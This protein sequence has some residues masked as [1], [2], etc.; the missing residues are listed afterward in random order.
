MRIV[1]A[2]RP[3]PPIPDDVPADHPL[4]DPIIDHWLESS[5]FA[6][7]VKM[8]A[9]R[10][11]LRLLGSDGLGRHLV[12]FLVAAG[13]GLS[14]DDLAVLTQTRAR[15]VERELSA[16]SGR[17]FQLRSAHWAT[18]GPHLY[19]LAHE[20]IQQS[21]LQ[22]IN[23]NELSVYRALLHQWADSYQQ[24]GWPE[25]TPEY[26]LR[27]Y[28]QLLRE[29][30]DLSQLVA[31][32]C[33]DARQERLWQV[34]GAD[35]EA[36][37]EIS[38]CF[39]HLLTEE[40]EISEQDTVTAL[41]LAISRDKL[42]D[43]MGHLPSSLVGIWAKL[44][45]VDRAINLARSQ[46]QSY[47]GERS[48]IA[49]AEALAASHGS[50][51]ALALAN[52]INDS[53]RRDTCLKEIAGALAR[54]GDTEALDVACGILDPGKRAGAYTA[55]AYELAQAR[56]RQQA[57]DTADQ[58][59]SII[60]EVGDAFHRA[61]LLATV[62]RVFSS[63]DN[64]GRAREIVDQAVSA[65]E[66]IIPVYRRAQA[67][68][69]VAQKI[70]TPDLAVVAADTSLK[71][72]NLVLTLDVDEEALWALRIVAA[73]LAATGLHEQAIELCH[74]VTDDEFDRNETLSEI[75]I[76][77]AKAGDP[78]H[79][80]ELS[81]TLPFAIHEAQVLIAAAEA[82][83]KAGQESRAVDI[84]HR[85]SEVAVRTS[86]SWQTEIMASAAEVLKMAG[87]D[88]QAT[89]V[90]SEA[91]ELARNQRN[92]RDLV[93]R[94]AELAMALSQ[95]SMRGQSL[96]LVRRARVIA[97]T[98][99]HLYGRIIGLA[100]VAKTFVGVGLDE[101]ARALFAHLVEIARSEIL[102]FERAES[103]SNIAICLAEAG[104][105][106]EAS[107]LATEILERSRSAPSPYREEWEKNAAARA[108]IAAEA[109][110]KAGALLHELPESMVSE[111][112]SSTVRGLV[113]AGQLDRA[114][115]I[116]EDIEDRRER[117]RALGYLAG[118][119]AASGDIPE[120][121]HLL[122]DISQQV[123]KDRAIPKIV[124]AA[125]KSG[126]GTAALRLIEEI[127]S[128]QYQ[129][130]AF[131]A[132]AA[133]LGPTSQGRLFLVRALSLGHWSSLIGDTG[134]VAPE[135]LSVVAD[136]L[137]ED[138]SRESLF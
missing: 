55:I 126:N 51:Q 15:L 34:T 54:T 48:L 33:D 69:R 100:T 116:M 16:V 94:L 110:D 89:S 105:L 64:S 90:A 28:A 114:F 56:K 12:G 14:A 44:G 65:A 112:L 35:L 27:G 128:E 11:L 75:G 24:R 87:L 103:L 134:Y 68:G 6:Q 26:L 76:A 120:A 79:A 123:M 95:V 20:E 32:A 97:E 93:R 78:E 73:A 138:S 118:A 37:T 52:S 40:T 9:E 31:L 127:D 98:E 50:R 109:Y 115:E 121:I 72:A 66:T 63:I 36:L 131:G 45:N 53:T 84:V 80:L 7:A 39:D 137:L 106:R 130:S 101:E 77:L 57:E 111:L 62:A 46:E 13:G 85:V 21:A 43:R 71:A 17:S 125:T 135:T 10:D 92:I 47:R 1:V 19:L 2:G 88:D 3:H 67:L 18:S 5:H 107:D 102:P 30:G 117:E 41:S 96:T 132:I 70:A 124:G 129:S 25:S 38:M 82:L 136:Y 74:R 119:L 22:L 104:N 29:V 8:D 83:V 58:S 61:E 113:T 59:C 4:R 122:D 108:F 23:D 42:R 91:T 99:P 86:F 60:A 49:V 81:R 133:S